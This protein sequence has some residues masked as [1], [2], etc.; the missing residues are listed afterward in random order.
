MLSSSSTGESARH[1]A[2]KWTC[3]GKPFGKLDTGPYLLEFLPR[4]QGVCFRDYTF[5]ANAPARFACISLQSG[6]R[7]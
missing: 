6:G 7:D 2:L 1:P 4:C 3:G 5:S